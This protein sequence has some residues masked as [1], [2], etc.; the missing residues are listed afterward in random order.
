[1]KLLRRTEVEKIC[2]LSRSAI[3]R[4]IRTGKFPVPVKI[5]GGLRGPVRWRLDEIEAWLEA[6]PRAT[7]ERDVA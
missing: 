5:A 2:G 7:G 4:L 6:L 3:Y 1:M